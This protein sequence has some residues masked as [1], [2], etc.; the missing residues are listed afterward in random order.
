MEF[1][2]NLKIN[3]ETMQKL[4][5][6]ANAYKMQGREREFDLTEKISTAVYTAI[7][8][9]ETESSEE[10]NEKMNIA[11]NLDKVIRYGKKYK[12]ILEP[13]WNKVYSK[14][15]NIERYM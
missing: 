8:E 11:M 5:A 9:I 10:E 4:N 7:L 14:K 12:D 6:V 3:N 1:K 2:E 13:F 15:Q